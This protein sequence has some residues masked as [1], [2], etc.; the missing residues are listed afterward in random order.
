MILRRGLGGGQRVSAISTDALPGPEDLAKACELLALWGQPM[1]FRVADDQTAL[2]AAL[3]HRGYSAHDPTVILAGSIDLPQPAPLAA[4]PVWPPLSLGE[5]IWDKSGVG[6][7]RR[8]VMDRVSGPKTA[9]LARLGDRP[10]GMCFAAMDQGRVMVH[11]LTTLP[12]ARGQGVGRNLLLGAA[13][14]GREIG[15][16]TLSM[17]TLRRNLPAFG[18][19]AS[20]GLR[21]V[22][23]YHYRQKQS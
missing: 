7:A 4:L 17:V 19:G 22:G 12:D 18:L 20:I 16:K 1:L 23:Q 8:A 9:L 10:A 6:P 21:A 13:A 11:A 5:E 15:A 3:A 14:W 2:D